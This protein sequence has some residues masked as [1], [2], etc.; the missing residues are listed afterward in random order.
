[1]PSFGYEGDTGTAAGDLMAFSEISLAATDAGPASNDRKS[2]SS[3]SGWGKWETATVASR[4]PTV[5]DVDM[6]V[7]MRQAWDP[8]KFFNAALGKFICS[9]DQTFDAVKD[10]EDHLRS[11]AHAAGV[12]R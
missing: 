9:C 12:A 5:F 8:Y 11:G 4:T 1:M 3:V 6:A 10:F 7:T 2:L